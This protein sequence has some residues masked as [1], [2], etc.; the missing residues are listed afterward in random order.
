MN[1]LNCFIPNY[2]SKKQYEAIHKIEY[3]LREQMKAV[4][5]PFLSNDH[6]E[7]ETFHDIDTAVKTVNK[8][9]KKQKEGKKK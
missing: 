4:A 2:V 1:E 6:Y 8:R 7:V 5:R 9:Y 3:I